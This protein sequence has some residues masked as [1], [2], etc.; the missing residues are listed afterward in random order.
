M[1]RG[2]RA[3]P[4]DAAAPAVGAQEADAEAKAA[5]KAAKEWNKEEHRDRRVDDWRKFQNVQRKKSRKAGLPGEFLPPK[6]KVEEKKEKESFGG[7][8]GNSRVQ[9]PDEVT[10]AW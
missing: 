6:P 3:P 7:P 5:A 8:K 4:A 2:S 1:R 10:R 9:R